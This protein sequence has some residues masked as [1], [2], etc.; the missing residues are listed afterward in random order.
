MNPSYYRISLDIHDATSQLSFSIKK[1]DTNRRLLISLT[2]NGVPYEITG[3][4][5]AT[6][7]ARKADKQ[8]VFNDCTIQKNMIIYDITEQ[9]SSVEGRLDCEITLNGE[10]GQQITSPRFTIIVYASVF[11]EE[12]VESSSEYKSL[13]TLVSETRG[14]IDKCE[15]FVDELEDHIVDK[16]LSIEGNAAD[17]KATGEAIKS[18]K[19]VE[20]VNA[21]VM[22]FYP[23][24]AGM[25][26]IP[27][28]TTAEC[29]N[30]STLMF[31][32]NKV[33][34]INASDEIGFDVVKVV[35]FTNS[36]GNMFSVLVRSRNGTPVIAS[37][38]YKEPEDGLANITFTVLATDA[39]IENAIATI[40]DSASIKYYFEVWDMYP[41]GIGRIYAPSFID[42]ELGAEIS[43][44]I[45]QGKVVILQCSDGMYN[46]I[47]YVPFIG[48]DG[49]MS[50]VSKSW[51]GTPVLITYKYKGG[52]GEGFY[53]EYTALTPPKETVVLDIPMSIQIDNDV[54][55]YPPTLSKE[56]G[57]QIY[58][59]LIDGKVVLL[60]N[61]DFKETIWTPFIGG[62]D[63]VAFSVMTSSES[64][65]TVML[66]YKLNSQTNEFE[67]TKS[68]VK[69]A[70]LY[71]HDITV[72]SWAAV[73]FNLCFTVY[74][75]RSTAYDNGTVFTLKQDIAM[76]APYVDSCISCSGYWLDNPSAKCY[77]IVKM[78]LTSGDQDSVTCDYWVATSSAIV[79]K[80]CYLDTAIFQDIV[81]KIL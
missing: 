75:K 77:P 20:I 4:C 44:N 72:M 34:Q 11:S 52:V 13:A 36:D 7:S 76:D 65:A 57:S 25:T 15:A 68:V 30:I 19:K 35:P 59:N 12:E 60:R 40:P 2:D 6:F 46:T 14:I 17:A 29:I 38:G 74:S 21:L 70:S 28:L 69:E 37:Y 33:V 61:T 16:T 64:G 41:E 67:A 49:G 23:E 53:P 78:K 47:T 9:T 10:Y 32:Q 22:D 18:A 80:T 81:T 43:S 3:D 66:T 71:R 1:G 45:V 51:N 50:M 26:F 27:Y 55:F 58:Q 79:K 8:I 63:G 54:F 31:Q 73:E 39:D 24:G 62:T 48:S 42:L 56:L 5:Y